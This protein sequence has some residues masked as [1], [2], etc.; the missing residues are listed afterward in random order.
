MVGVGY[1]RLQKFGGASP[2][3]PRARSYLLLVSW[4][5]CHNMSDASDIQKNFQLESAQFTVAQKN[6]TVTYWH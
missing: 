6:L 2:K 5:L 3:L 4:Q 1:D